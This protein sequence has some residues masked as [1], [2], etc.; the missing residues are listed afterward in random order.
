MIPNDP[1]SQMIA[2]HEG[3][4]SKMYVDTMGVPTIGVGR[5]LRDVG[6][7]EYEIQY[8]FENDLN[9]AKLLARA[10]IGFFD[11][12]SQVRQDVLVDMIFNMGIGEVLCFREMLNA[13]RLEDYQSASFEMLKSHWAS[14]VGDRATELAHMMRTDTYLP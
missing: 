14:Q 7:R 4:K 12:L 11:T 9:E 6:L 2:R 8:L 1:L 13:L 10:H 3:V 5:N